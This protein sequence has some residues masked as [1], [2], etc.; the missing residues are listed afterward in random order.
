MRFAAVVAA[1]TGSIGIAGSRG[2][3]S[4][5]SLAG[6]GSV[7]IAFEAAA[8]ECKASRTITEQHED[9]FIAASPA[10]KLSN[11]SE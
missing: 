5:S 9:T 2:S 3:V 10:S 8:V 4:S 11:C 6:I 7:R 1:A